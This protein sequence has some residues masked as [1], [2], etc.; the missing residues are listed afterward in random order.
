M[1]DELKVA[2]YGLGNLAKGY[3]ARKG[4]CS[5]Q[6]TGASTQA[7]LLELEPGIVEIARAGEDGV[8][9]QTR[10]QVPQAAGQGLCILAMAQRCLGRGVG[11]GWVRGVTN[12]H[13]AYHTSRAWG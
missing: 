11:R 10:D 2:K 1:R 12:A 9:L 7:G 5:F 3:A 6:S 8:A 4:G 13:R